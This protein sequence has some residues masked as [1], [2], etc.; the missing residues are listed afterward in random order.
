MTDKLTL[1][2]TQFTALRAEIL[3]LMEANEK[4]VFAACGFATASWGA[5]VSLLSAGIPVPG[6]AFLAPT[7]VLILALNIHIT[8][9]RRVA[10]IGSFLAH[11]VAVIAPDIPNWEQEVGVFANSSGI[12][13][14]SRVSILSIYISVAMVGCVGAIVPPISRA[15]S[16]G[17]GQYKIPSSIQQIS[18]IDV[19]LVATCSLSILVVLVLI[20][21][22]MDYR[23]YAVL[24]QNLDNYWRARFNGARSLPCR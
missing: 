10:N 9:G 14:S 19:D 15:L 22:A 13:M 8:H 11:A 2:S 12:R 5:L 17:N 20:S 18:W 16:K 21:S 24:R 3:Q 6:I 7:A 4:R 23:S 1:F